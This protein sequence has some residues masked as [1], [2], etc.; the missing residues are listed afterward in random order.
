MVRSCAVAYVHRH[1]DSLHRG[2]QPANLG[3]F[4]VANGVHTPVQA[5]KATNLGSP[6]HRL[7]AQTAPDQLGGRQHAVLGRGCRRDPLI[8]S[9][10]RLVNLSLTFR[11]IAGHAPQ[12]D[13]G[14]RADPGAS[15]TPA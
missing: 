13:A 5:V 2:S 12:G 11:P 14:R 10:G 3:D 6:C 8:D 9:S 4:G 1:S 7:P 15:V